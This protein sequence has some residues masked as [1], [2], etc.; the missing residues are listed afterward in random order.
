MKST[1]I[2]PCCAIV[3]IAVASSAHARITTKEQQVETDAIDAKTP[4][5]NYKATSGFV[6]SGAESPA[7]PGHRSVWCSTVK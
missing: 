4:K 1:R 2:L 7:G 3:A 6:I 5:L